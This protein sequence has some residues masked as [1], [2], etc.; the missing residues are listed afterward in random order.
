MPRPA[1]KGTKAKEKPRRRPM[2]PLRGPP[3]GTY[4]PAL[5][6]QLRASQRGLTDLLED[7]G[8]ERGRLT[9][10]YRTGRRIARRGYGRDVSDVRREYSRG[11]ED[12]GF[13]RSDVGT[14]FARDL[15]E[16]AVARQRGEQDYDRTLTGLQREYAAQAFQQE[17][18]ALSAGVDQGG[19]PEASRLVRGANQAYEKGA[20]DLE[21]QRMLAD[22]GRREGFLTEDFGTD[23]QRLDEALSRMGQ[24]FG[25][26]T[27]RMRTDFL[28]ERR[29]G[30]REF[31]RSKADLSQRASRAKREQGLYEPS[32]IE[33]M[34]YQARQYN[35]KI[36]FP[37][38]LRAGGRTTVATPS[39]GTAVPRR[40]RR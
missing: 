30:R 38:P 23:N 19:A 22:L 14:S 26:N 12:V 10:D 21:H 8:R 28:T 5:D 36:R 27:G 15:Q 9:G 31:R 25:I 39:G 40:R 33:Q 34:Y 35:P 32:A 13:E 29:L 1:A 24:D 7:V 37:R 3:L 16:L 18:G 20:I 17:Q 4:D 11:Q 2:G 6:Y